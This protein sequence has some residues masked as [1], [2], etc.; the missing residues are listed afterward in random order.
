MTDDRPRT[1]RSGVPHKDYSGR[2]TSPGYAI[3]DFV[4]PEATGNYEGEEL[5]RIRAHREPPERMA[6]LERRVDRLDKDMAVGFAESNT[7]LDTLL[8]L[9]AKAEAERER[10]SA[11]DHA[12]EERRRKYVLALIGALAAA[13]AVVLPALARCS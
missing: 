4:E 7:R 12:H 5:A 11:A 3:P 6:H 13:A 2:K 1:P 10:R 8:E 9:A